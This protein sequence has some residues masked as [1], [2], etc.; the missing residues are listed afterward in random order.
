MDIFTLVVLIFILLP[1]TG[2]LA[3]QNS[4]YYLKEM[5]MI[6]PVVFILTALLDTWVPKETIIK[7]L[8]QGSNLKGII[9]S[10][11]LG[12]ISAGPVYAAFPICIMLLG[13]GAVASLNATTP[14]N[15]NR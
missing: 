14:L 13:K 5:L 2:V 15:V 10:F 11:V 9:L 8:G 3:I 4:S 7:Y 6:M 12:A 1:K